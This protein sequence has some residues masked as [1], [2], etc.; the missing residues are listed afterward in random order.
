MSFAS[1]E[2]LRL[3]AQ[4]KGRGIAGLLRTFPDRM[5]NGTRLL[6]VSDEQA[7]KAFLSVLTR[8]LPPSHLS[9]HP[10]S[11]KMAQVISTSAMSRGEP[12]AARYGH[13]KP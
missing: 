13:K 5:L 4:Q 11:F 1:Q 6:R 9:P 7:L 10:A 2:V 12:G 3:P 8:W